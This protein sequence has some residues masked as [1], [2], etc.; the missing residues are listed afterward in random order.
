MACDF[1]SCLKILI[2][3]LSFIIA[4][5]LMEKKIITIHVCASNLI[6]FLSPNLR[7]QKCFLEV[8][9]GDKNDD[10]YS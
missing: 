4:S 6:N 7:S 10:H 1:K 5:T 3:S 9:D 2:F 8:G